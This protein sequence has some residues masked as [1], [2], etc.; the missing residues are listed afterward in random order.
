MERPHTH[1]PRRIRRE[2]E[3]VWKLRLIGTLTAAVYL[4][5]CLFYARG[6]EAHTR[7]R[8][9]IFAWVCVLAL[10][11]L[12]WK[13][14][15]TV[16]EFSDERATR[17]IV[18]FA[19]V[20]CLFAALTIPFHST[21]AFGYINRGWQQVHYGQNPYVYRVADVPLW[22]QD[23][24]L[25]HHW[26][27][28]P[29]PYGFLFSLL[30]RFLCWLGGGRWRLTLALFKAANVSAYILTAWLIWAG[31]KL[32]G[33]ERPA[34]ALFVFLWNPLILMHHIANG[35]NDI[36]VGC[37]LALC[38][39]L[40]IRGGRLWIIPLLVAATFLKYAPALLLPP[41]LIF[42]YRKSGWRSVALGSLLGA[43]LAVAVCFPYLKDWE[44]IRLE[45]I[46]D[47]ATL[48][49]NSLHSFLF[50]L[51]GTLAGLVKPLAP[52]REPLNEIFKVVLRGGFL[53]FYAALVW[54][55]AKGP[56]LDAFKRYSLLALFVL[57]CFVSSKLNAWYLG[58]LL[59][60]ALL[61]KQDDWLRRLIVL[62]SLS[63]LLSLTF[64]KQAYMLNFFAMIL[65]PTLIV[66]RQTR[67][68]RRPKSTRDT[69]QPPGDLLAAPQKP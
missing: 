51:Y 12:F 63:E 62:I 59:P 52:Y 27:Y 69:P 25:R 22:Q 61:L 9:E 45:D 38:F 60:P 66:Y 4:F 50:H 36:L 67:R 48:L 10:L 21:D 18:A 14:Y 23:P 29:N 20:F 2:R 32:L 47:N 42:I 31:A 13:G 68:E 26:P 55:I 56:S 34:L 57:I 19:A 11:P 49:D 24:M 58:I 41:A 43:A 3:D 6:A 39:Y 64:F 28:N 1:D 8:R 30:A 40:A 35:H 53:L 15:K 44:L 37:L 46:R 17:T 16:K 65:V 54:R 5:A 33:H 7:T